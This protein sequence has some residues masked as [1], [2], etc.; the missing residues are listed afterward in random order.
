[1]LQTHWIQDQQ[2]NL[3]KLR[4]DTLHLHKGFAH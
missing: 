2:V 3:G 1:M 4:I